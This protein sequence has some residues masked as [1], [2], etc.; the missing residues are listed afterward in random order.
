MISNDAENRKEKSTKI[1]KDIL[2]FWNAHI[3]TIGL[4]VL[5]VIFISSSAYFALTLKEGIIPDEPHHFI[6]SKLFASTWGIPVDTPETIPYGIINHWPFLS[7]WINARVLN[8]LSWIAPILSDRAVLIIFRLLGVIYSTITAIYGYLFAKEIIRNRWG[9]LF[10]VFLLTNTLMF[11]FLSGGD[12]YDNLLNLCCFAGIYYLTCVFNGKPFYKYSF[13]WLISILIASLIKITILPLAV[14]TGLLWIIYIVKQRQAIN[15]KFTWDHKSISTILILSS[16][17]VIN[18]AIYGVNIIR[19]RTLVP[20]CIQEFTTSQCMAYPQFVRDMQLEVDLSLSDVVS[21]GYP[22]PV[23]YGFDY[24]V[25]SMLQRIYGIMGHQNYFPDVSIT[26]HRL[27]ILWTIL[28]TI[29]YWKKPSYTIAGLYVILLFYVMILFL[30]N[31]N[32]ELGFGFKHAGIQGRY[33]FPV[34]G[35]YYTMMVYYFFE[36][37]GL[38]LRRLTFIYTT[39]L[40]LYGSPIVFFLRIYPSL[41]FY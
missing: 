37:P 19:Y 36:I 26:V 12:S 3:T 10:V 27:L 38:V 11:V 16:L 41:L 1:K 30:N 13:L 7:Y 22:D 28:I 2:V 8:L 31:Y 5:L 24:W 29:R 39:I 35:I 9:Q 40:F 4:I 23:E 34:I 18:F 17:I 33:I 32:T 21:E 25:V 20:S 15:F 6:V 14:I